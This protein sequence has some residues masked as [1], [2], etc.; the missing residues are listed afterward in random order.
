MCVG[1]MFVR[2]SLSWREFQ[3]L[4]FFSLC[5]C[6]ICAYVYFSYYC[7]I[8]QEGKLSSALGSA[9]PGDIFKISKKTAI[10]VASFAQSLNTFCPLLSCCPYFQRVYSSKFLSKP[11]VFPPNCVILHHSNDVSQ[12]VHTRVTQGH[13]VIGK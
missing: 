7:L 11:T 6:I 3:Q 10:I 12:Q 13:A 5:V 1:F 9:V 8:K 4:A 2:Y